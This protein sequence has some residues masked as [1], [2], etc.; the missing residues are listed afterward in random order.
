[1][2]ARQL[3]LHRY[4]ADQ[5]SAPRPL[6]FVHGGYSNS[7]LWEENF[8]PYFQAKGY[9][10]LAVDLSGHGE[11]GGREELDSLG[12]ADFAED[13]RDALGSVDEV[14]ILIAH[15]MGCLVVQ[16]YLSS[17][18]EPHAA[19]VAFLAPVPPSGTLGSV[20]RLAIS[21][22]AFFEELPRAVSGQFGPR[23][24]EVMAAVYFSPQMRKEDTLKYL[25][26]LE[27]ESDHAVAEMVMNPLPL[28][29][30]RPR[31]PALVMGGSADAVFPASML[32]F[33]AGI[34]NAERIVIEGAGHMLM[35]D[36]QW[37]EAVTELRGWIERLD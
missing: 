25:P 21:H 36:P 27:E 16:H 5:R 10:C 13:V 35:L 20:N 26:M 11:S 12:L 9:D 29:S 34:W 24:L 3:K 23:T 15:S 14:P 1:M 6:F 4:P 28:F 33:T 7:R 37:P 19:A 32:H 18:R 31:I 22:P 30:R 8:I 17:Q 2:S